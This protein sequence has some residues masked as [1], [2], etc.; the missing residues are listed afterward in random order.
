[1]V[2]ALSFVKQKTEARSVFWG[3]AIVLSHALKETSRTSTFFPR[4]RFQPQRSFALVFSQKTKTKNKKK[5]E[6]P[7]LSAWDFNQGLPG[8]YLAQYTVL[9]ENDLF[10]RSRDAQVGD[11]H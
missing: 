4:F 2:A 9:R 8:R 10:V 3:G 1:M 11:N 6:V 5:A 7:I